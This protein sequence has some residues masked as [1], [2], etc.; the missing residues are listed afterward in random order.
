M[1]LKLS[2]MS[3]RLKIAIMWIEKAKLAVIIGRLPS[4]SVSIPEGNCN[5]IQRPL[6]HIGQISNCQLLACAQISLER[7]QRDASPEIELLEGIHLL[8]GWVMTNCMYSV[9]H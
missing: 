6:L 3:R 5:I 2:G 4:V 9:Q 8:S 1:I 7:W